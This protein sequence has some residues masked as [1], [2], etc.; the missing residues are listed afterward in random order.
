MRKLLALYCATRL[1]Y[2]KE[3]ETAT[4][5]GEP[6]KNDTKPAQSRAE[7]AWTLEDRKL[8]ATS[9]LEEFIADVLGEVQPTCIKLPTL[10]ELG[11]LLYPKRT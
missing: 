2:G 5:T 6:K 8:L 7:R 1:G 3:V 10:K 11:L 9:G 4:G